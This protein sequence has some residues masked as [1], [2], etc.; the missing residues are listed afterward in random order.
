MPLLP[1]SKDFFYY[2]YYFQVN[3]IN[4]GLWHLHLF[5]YFQTLSGQGSEQPGLTLKLALL[6][7]G[8]LIGWPPWIPSIVNFCMVVKTQLQ[9]L[10]YPFYKG[11]GKSVL[12]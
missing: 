10:K 5:G 4:E 1:H 12:F 11:Q 6:G 9:L 3:A 8:G 7:A 2:Y